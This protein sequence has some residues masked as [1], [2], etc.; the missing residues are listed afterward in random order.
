MS[1]MTSWWK[2]DWLQLEND[3]KNILKSN[4]NYILIYRFNFWVEM[5][6][7]NINNNNN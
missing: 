5:N 1:D 6:I 7:K 3:C 2:Q 4:I